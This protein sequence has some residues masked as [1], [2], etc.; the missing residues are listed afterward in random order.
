MTTPVYVARLTCET[1]GGDGRFKIIVGVFSNEK[2]GEE[3]IENFV[4]GTLEI[5][6]SHVNVVSRQVEEF[7]LDQPID[8]FI[9]ESVRAYKDDIPF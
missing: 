3:A 4:E 5:E 9:D 2:L 8:Q 7:Q 1:D 6:Y